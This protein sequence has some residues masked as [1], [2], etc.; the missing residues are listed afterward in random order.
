MIH[1]FIID[2]HKMVIE[3]LELLLQHHQKIAVVGAAMSG[4]EGI[5]ALTAITANVV[6]LDINMPG[7]NGSDT[8]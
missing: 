5:R 4:E 8:C 6:L 7:L 2:D 1:V 3:G